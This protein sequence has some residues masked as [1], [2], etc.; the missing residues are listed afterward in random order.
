MASTAKR[1]VQYLSIF[2]LTSALSD[3]RMETV[4][5][6]PGLKAGE[7]EGT[8]HALF[9]GLRRVYWCARFYT[10][11]R[12]ERMQ[13]SVQLRQTFSF[14]IVKLHGCKQSSICSKGS[15]VS[16]IINLCVIVAES[17]KN[18]NQVLYCYVKK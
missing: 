2:L 15:S 11:V 12:M 7:G 13:I 10:V 18:F 4:C 17:L 16:V 8:W 9:S 6:G 3:S 14:D 5:K 1:Q